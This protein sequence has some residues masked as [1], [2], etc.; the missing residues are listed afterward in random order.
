MNL[1]ME[2]I[3]TILSFF[4][5]S[6]YLFSVVLVT[7]FLHEDNSEDNLIQ[8]LGKALLCLTLSLIA[9][10]IVVP[11]ILGTV[12]GNKIKEY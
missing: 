9:S 2:V 8:L 10:P 3:I 1:I 12:I 11:I 6:Y 5:F 4:A 7:T